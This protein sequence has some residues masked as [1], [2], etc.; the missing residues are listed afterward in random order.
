[1]RKPSS[2]FGSQKYVAGSSRRQG[3]VGRGT[4][5]HHIPASWRPQH[6]QIEGLSLALF[7]LSCH[8]GGTCL[9]P[10]VPEGKG[11]NWKLMAPHQRAQWPGECC[12]DVLHPLWTLWVPNAQSPGQGR[13]DNIRREE[14]MRTGTILGMRDR[15]ESG[16]AWRWRLSGWQWGVFCVHINDGF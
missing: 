1:M 16:G 6:W 14:D 9:R 4:I 15:E 2:L 5:C 13:G 7:S 10:M 8:M 11:F 12:S 3:L